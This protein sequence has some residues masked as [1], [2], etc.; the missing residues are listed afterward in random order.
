MSKNFDIWITGNLLFQNT[1]CTAT[2]IVDDANMN[3]KINFAM[4]QV[5]QN[6]EIFEKILYEIMKPA[7][8]CFYFSSIYFNRCFF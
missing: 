1:G 4:D 2:Q 7:S 8:F 6:I 5:L 3:I